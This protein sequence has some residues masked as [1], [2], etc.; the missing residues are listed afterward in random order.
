MGGS[1]KKLC[2][3][4]LETLLIA[5]CLLYHLVFVQYTVTA[6]LLTRDL[7]FTFLNVRERGERAR[8]HL[9][10][11]LPARRTAFLARLLPAQ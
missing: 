2:L 4:L 10:A 11:P 5:A 9:L 8:R 6:G 1:L 7:V 3:S